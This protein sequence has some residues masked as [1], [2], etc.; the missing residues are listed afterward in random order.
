MGKIVALLFILVFLASPFIIIDSHVKAIIPAIIVPDDYSTI[1]AAIGNAAD[2]DTIFVRKGTYEEH[3][4]AITKSLSLVGEDADLTVIKNLKGPLISEPGF[5]PPLY[6][7]TAIEINSSNV[8]VS[9]F[10][11]VD[12]GEP[13]VV[14]GNKTLIT[15][16]IIWRSGSGIK[17]EGNNNTIANNTVLGVGSGF[18]TCTGS[19]NI[20]AGNS[21]TGDGN[22]DGIG[23]YGSFNVVYDNT[24][25]DSGFG[26]EVR[27]NANTLAR[28]NMTDGGLIFDRDSSNNSIW[29]NRA[30]GVDLMGFNN[31]FIANDVGYVSIGGFHGG[32]TDAADNVFY[33]NNFEGA[34]EL[35]VSTKAPG[36]LVWDN[37]REGNYWSSYRG[38]DADG[39]GIGDE[40]YK[41]FASYSYYDGIVREDALVD[42][43][44]DNHPLMAPFDIDSVPID[45]PEWAVPVTPQ[46]FILPE[47][48]P[49][50]P[51]VAASVASIAFAGA[52]ALVYSRKRKRQ[53]PMAS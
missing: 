39:D 40:A 6:E 2:G 12:S 17:L 25:K 14:R 53:A 42:C 24:L 50:A 26:I 21:M 28:N 44:K 1:A 4:L 38:V 36:L 16:N 11:I 22:D 43:G 33:H 41:V 49:T 27:G 13:I 9:G 3:K 46:E 23:I 20:I 51:V 34:P 7:V 18:I 19:Y 37:G 45:L 8:R 29:A 32:S 35:R 47:P 5:V 52:G 31:T 10:T 48:F 30:L 15:G